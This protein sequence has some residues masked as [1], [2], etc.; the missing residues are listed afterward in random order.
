VAQDF[1]PVP[2]QLNIPA[3]ARGRAAEWIR[4]EGIQGRPV[5]G[6]QPAAGR[7]I[8]EWDPIR[9]A[10]TGAELARS[11]G[12]TIM[13]I[14]SAHDAHASAAVKAA[15]PRDLRLVEL[16]TETGLVDL[17]AVLEQL[18]LF[19]TG[20]TGPM[21]LAA[22]VGVPVLAIFGPSLPTR[23][24]PLS[25]RARIVRID[26]PCSPCNRMRQPPER[27]VGIIPDCLSGIPTTQVLQAAR[28]MLDGY[29]TSSR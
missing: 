23:Y 16:P 20:D 8:K 5:V 21:H 18:D 1:S 10:E 2:A 6:I 12:A 28:E 17:A 15:W 19:I 26:L 14:A 7:K 4:R 27:C 3:D 25:P 9:F 29:G 13:L 22:A 24:A 11:R